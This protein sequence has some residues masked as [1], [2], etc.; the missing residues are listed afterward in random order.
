M[1]VSPFAPR[2]LVEQLIV[3]L[4]ALHNPYPLF[5][6]H[7]LHIPKRDFLLLSALLLAGASPEDAFEDNLWRAGKREGERRNVDGPKSCSSKSH[8]RDDQK[9]CGAWSEASP[10]RLTPWPYILDCK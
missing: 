7:R 4:S 3:G 2:A 10:R 9:V 6:L 5:Y 8:G 1:N